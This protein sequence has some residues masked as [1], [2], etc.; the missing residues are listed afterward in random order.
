[1]D[2][3]KYHGLGND[4]I[5]IDPSKFKEKLTPEVIRFICDRNHGIG[6]DGVLYGPFF[7]NGNI[8]LKIYNPD[9]SEAEKSGNG[10]RI[11]S[12]YCF[13]CEYVKGAEF[14][15]MTKGGAVDVEMIDKAK[16]V[17]K[18]KIGK[19][20][21]ANKDIPTSFEEELLLN[22]SL[23][24]NDVIFDVN[25]VSVGN[26]HCVIF[27]DKDLVS[28]AKKWGAAIEKHEFFPQNINVQFAKVKDRS[29]IDVAIW[30][31]GAGYTL[32]SG[33]SSCAVA[34]VAYQLGLVDEN[35]TISMPGGKLKVEISEDIVYLT[36]KVSRV[37]EG[38]FLKDFKELIRSFNNGSAF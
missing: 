28:E 19:Y 2:F 37:A 10:I 38:Y 36:G 27:S 20:S 23:N 25:C 30:E 35:V 18:V 31:R 12:L 33:T 15:L 9:G 6:G 11:F 7:E 16:S 5:V 8:S 22:R 14:V 29:N 13:D 1:M 21:F 34:S 4:Y 32:A 3:Y 26:P 24:V 17:L